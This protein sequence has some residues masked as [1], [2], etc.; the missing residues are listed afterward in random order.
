GPDLLDR[1]A[2]LVAGDHRV[3]DVGGG[4]R[5][6]QHLD[7]AHADAGR[8]DL[9][10]DLSVARAWL[11]FVAQGGPVRH[12]DDDGLHRPKAMLLA[13]GCQETARLRSCPLIRAWTSSGSPTP[14]SRRRS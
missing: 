2:P 12:V 3:L 13:P 10:Q 6:L 4:T 5:A 8:G 11:G 1:P 14:R 9:D 7:V